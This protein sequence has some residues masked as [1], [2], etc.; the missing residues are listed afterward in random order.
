M[1]ADS[2][3]RRE[4]G[5]LNGISKYSTEEKIVG[6][7]DKASNKARDL[8][9]KVKERLGSATGNEDLEMKGKMDQTKAAFKN[10][11]EKVKDAGTEKW[12]VS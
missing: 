11:G 12:T 10:V 7:R 5:V 2:R 8:K 9:G 6:T 3:H 4:E 1:D